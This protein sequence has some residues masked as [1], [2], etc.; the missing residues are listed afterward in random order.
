[1]LRPL[2]HS[3][4]RHINIW[5]ADVHPIVFPVFVCQET[6]VVVRWDSEKRFGFIKPDQGGQERPQ[7]A[8]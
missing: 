7:I 1:M 2:P 4:L 5:T 3:W 6:G 8:R